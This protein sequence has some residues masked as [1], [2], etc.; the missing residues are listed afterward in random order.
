MLAG[1]HMD[2]AVSVLRAADGKARLTVS[3]TGTC[4]VCGDTF[5]R[6]RSTQTI[7]AK[8]KCATQVGKVQRKAERAE[9]KRRKEAAKPRS[10]YMKEAQSEFNRYIRLRDAGKPCISCGR[11]HQGQWHAGHYLSTGARPELRFDEDNCHRQCQPCNT[12]LHGNLLRYRIAL[13]EKLGLARLK[14]LE[15]PHGAAKF[16]IPD[17]ISIRDEYRAKAKELER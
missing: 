9:T 16:T 7:C 11:D 13:I 14:H 3:P 5:T 12:H 17:L 1:I 4:K 15:G 10:Q 6:F 2:V 8:I